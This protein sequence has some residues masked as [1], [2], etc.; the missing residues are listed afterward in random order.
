MSKNKL[1]KFIDLDSYQNV[2]QNFSYKSPVLVSQSEEKQMKGNWAEKHFGNKNPIVLELACGMGHYTIALARKYPNKNFI[3]ID[4]KGA[5]IWNGAT[6]AI[7]EKLD[8]AAFLRIKIEQIEEFF[9]TSEVDEIWITFPDP[10][11]KKSR[12]NNRLTSPR[13]IARYRNIVKE[14]AIIQLK[15][16]SPELY[17]YTDEI[18]R[19]DSNI[20]ILYQNPDIYNKP[21]DF[22][23][24]EIKTYYEK[25]HLKNGRKITYTR[26]V[27]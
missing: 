4:I 14:G 21:L 15:T 18:L 26:F 25:K 9:D 19:A 22:D 12:A 11:L 27:L 5:R 7:N 6:I 13:F 20:D 8:N 1:K 2:Y 17:E 10:F 16:D 23:E 24:L 3:G